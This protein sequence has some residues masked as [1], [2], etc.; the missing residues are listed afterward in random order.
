[1]MHCLVLDE[2]S[3]EIGVINTNHASSRASRGVAA[4]KASKWDKFR[5]MKAS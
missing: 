5:F 4:N 3:L 1:M 2:I